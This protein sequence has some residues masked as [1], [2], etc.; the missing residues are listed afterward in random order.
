[1]TC[2]NGSHYDRFGRKSCSECLKLICHDQDLE[3]LVV[4]AAK[5]AIERYQS[6]EILALNRRVEELK[7]SQ[8][9]WR[10]RAKDLERQ[11]LDLTVLQQRLEKRKAHTAAL[12]VSSINF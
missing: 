3:A 7:E 8:E 1:M 12:K 6:S 9:E 11:V 5:A 4:S 10:Q 2:I